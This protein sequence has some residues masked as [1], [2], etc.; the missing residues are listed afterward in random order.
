VRLKRSTV[1]LVLAR[2]AARM[3][4]GEKLRREEGGVKSWRRGLVRGS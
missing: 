1:M 2:Q 4:G 3:L